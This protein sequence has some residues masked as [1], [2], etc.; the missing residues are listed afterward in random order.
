MRIEVMT[1]RGDE[2]VAEWN[3][4]TREEELRIIGKRFDQLLERG[5]SAFGTESGTRLPRFNPELDEDVVFIAPVR[6]G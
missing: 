3:R 4:D 6:G 5:Y 1:G 2:V